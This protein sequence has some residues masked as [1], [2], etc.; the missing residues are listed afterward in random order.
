MKRLVFMILALLITTGC[1][2][3]S[4]VN[5]KRA[6]E[7]YDEEVKNFPGGGIQ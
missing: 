3:I 1:V 2:S 4:E 5:Q 6:I 7:Y